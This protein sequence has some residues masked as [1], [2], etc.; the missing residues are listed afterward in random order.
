MRMTDDIIRP[1]AGSRCPWDECPAFEK[2][3]GGEPENNSP[4]FPNAPAHQTPGVAAEDGTVPPVVGNFC[5]AC[6]GKQLHRATV[7]RDG[8]WGS[9]RVKC[10]VCGQGEQDEP[11]SK[12]NEGRDER[13]EDGADAVPPQSRAVAAPRLATAAPG[14]SP[15]AA[16]HIANAR[17]DRQEEAR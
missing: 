17:L 6:L 11:R 10:R 2:R 13:A 14:S 8:Q 9:K 1:L 7:S 5:I 3:A 16:F 15:G 4:F 12:R